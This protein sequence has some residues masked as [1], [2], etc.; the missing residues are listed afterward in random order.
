VEPVITGIFPRGA[1]RGSEITVRIVGRNLG[2][3]ADLIVHDPGIELLETERV[4]GGE[5][6]CKV[7]IASDAALGVHAVRVRTQSGVSNL[8]LF[9]VGALTEVAETEPNGARD[10]ANVVGMESTVSGVIMREDADYFAVDLEAGQRL[11]VEIEAM[12]LGYAF[13]DPKLRLF[14]PG[15]HELLTE[16]D[17]AAL[18]QDAAFVHHAT[19]AG[20]HWVVVSDA[21]YGGSADH[22]YRLHIGS[23]PRP[24]AVT[25]LG[26]APGDEVVFRW[27]GDSGVD[28][29]AQALPLGPDGV[30]AITARSPEGESPTP[31]RVRVAELPGTM[32]QEP[33][34]TRDSATA[35][36]VP[37]AVDGVL[38][39]PGDVDY[40]RFTAKKDQQFEV[41]LWGRALGSPIDGVVRVRKAGGGVVAGNDDAVGLDSKVRVTIPED[42]EYYLEVHDHRRRGGETF[43][44]RVETSTQTPSLEI[45]L[46]GEPLARSVPRGSYIWLN[47]TPVR[48][49]MDE[50]VSVEFDNL[51]EGVEAAIVEDAA[52]SE[53]IAVLVRA[54]SDAPL[55]TT[56]VEVRGTGTAGT[57]EVR[58]GFGGHV[59]LIHGRNRTVFCQHEVDRIALAVVE[60]APFALEA[61]PPPV[62]GI[63][64]GY[65]DIPVRVTR[66]DGFT[67][68]IVLDMPLLP[69]KAGAG[70]VKIAP[71]QTDAALRIEAQ[72]GGP[73]GTYP[74][75]IRAKGGG[76]TVASPVIPVEIANPPVKVAVEPL[77][78]EQGNETA[79]V[80]KI[81]EKSEGRGPVELHLA[82]LPKGVS[83]DA[84]FALSEQAELAFPLTIAA[85]AR[86]G[87]FGHVVVQG[88]ETRGDHRLPF[89]LGTAQLRVFKPLPPKLDE[90]EPES[91]PDEPVPEKPK[92]PKTRFPTS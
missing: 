48:R 87:K 21:V 59:E 57:Q 56:L 83:S 2:D 24:L 16:D 73:A 19:E 11:A 60:A 65:V 6:A 1:A 51:P 62:P 30:V 26:G 58:G 71:D 54:A 52:G 70:A 10:Q 22:A 64:S 86:P 55:G 79:W 36:A 4:E 82:R 45:K 85:D 33:N 15:G 5:V 61:D 41:Q 13:F 91:K 81:V 14:G 38:N 69:D 28:T 18:G 35:V 74:T 34:N 42:G 43:A 27:L 84:R 3:F 75:V 66:A 25:P 8:R 40:Y 12:R 44:Y 7:A 76:H 67:G 31:L 32:E 29:T 90:P 89:V 37:G 20:R 47:L 78:V 17:T 68:E 49:N 9:S 23:F 63:R 46:T 92:P 39:E 80:A 77:H 53:Q 50:G 88:F 72:P